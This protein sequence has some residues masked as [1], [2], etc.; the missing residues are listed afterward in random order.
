M[1]HFISFKM[2]RAV[3]GPRGSVCN[4]QLLPLWKRSTP[5]RMFPRPLTAAMLTAGFEK[6]P[7]GSPEITAQRLVGL[8]NPGST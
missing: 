5:M 1:E 8:P 6:G 2:K 3:L 4:L 7:P